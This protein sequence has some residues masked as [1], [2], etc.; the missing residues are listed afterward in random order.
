MPGRQKPMY[1]SPEGACGGWC[2]AVEGG[3]LLNWVR[4]NQGRG[5]RNSGVFPGLC[6][7]RR[8]AGVE[9]GA[10]GGNRTMMGLHGGG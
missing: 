5:A 1:E 2:W 8:R 3:N 7:N 6:N 4:K 10:G 9:I